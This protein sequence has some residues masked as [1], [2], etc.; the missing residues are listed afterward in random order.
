MSVQD[1]LFHL[2]NLFD[3]ESPAVQEALMRELYCYGVDLE[4]DLQEYFPEVL[5]KKNKGLKRILDFFEE[6]RWSE[7]VKTS[8]HEETFFQDL[9]LSLKEESLDPLIK[10][11]LLPGTVVCHKRYAYRGVIVSADSECLAPDEWC[12]SNRSQPKKKQPWYHV[13]VHSLDQVTYVA[14]ANLLRDQSREQVI[15][16]LRNCFFKGFQEGVYVRNAVLWL[17]S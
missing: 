4:K 12:Q 16:P 10:E 11:M 9:E 1:K 14:Q 15:H 6:R 5:Q 13:L 7:Q 2:V 17:G 3:D 8:L